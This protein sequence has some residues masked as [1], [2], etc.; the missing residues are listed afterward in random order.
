M[1]NLREPRALAADLS[2]CTGN[3]RDED[4][5][6]IV[7]GR[8]GRY[9][10]SCTEAVPEAHIT[11]SVVALLIWFRLFLL[12]NA[13]DLYLSTFIF[14]NVR[15]GRRRCSGVGR[16]LAS[17]GTRREEGPADGVRR[18]VQFPPA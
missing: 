14:E 17:A 8:H 3:D 10:R 13:I 4:V 12:R 18:H 9:A 2:A 7:H 6:R 15:R 11:G 16:P 1:H 5:Y